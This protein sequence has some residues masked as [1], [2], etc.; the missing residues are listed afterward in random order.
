MASALFGLL[1]PACAA[2]PVFKLG[3]AEDTVVCDCAQQGKDKSV[4]VNE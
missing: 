2:S 4:A 1:S 3:N